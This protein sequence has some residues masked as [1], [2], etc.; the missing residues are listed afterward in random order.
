VIEQALL[1]KH[2]GRREDRRKD[3]EYRMSTMIDVMLR[4]IMALFFSLSN[5]TPGYVVRDRRPEF[6]DSL[7][8][9]KD[10]REEQ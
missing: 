3:R 7:H 10:H 4:H 6:P 8:T 9:Q 1:C 2:D 5:T